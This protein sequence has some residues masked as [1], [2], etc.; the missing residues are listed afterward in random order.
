MK[1]KHSFVVGAAALVIALFF[2]ACSNPNNPETNYTVTI[3]TLTNGS[4]TAAPQSGPEGTTIVLTVEPDAGYRQKA[5]SLKYNNGSAD[6]AITGTSFALPAANVTVS[7]EFEL[8]PANYNVIIAALTNGNVTAAPQ[9]GPQGTTIVLTVEPDA[10]YRLKADS[11]KYND[12]SVDVPITGTSFVMPDA[13]VTVSAEFETVP[14]GS[15]TVAIAS[16]TNGSVTAAPQYGPVGTTIVLTV[17][18]D[19]GYRLKADSLKYNNGSADVAITGTSFALP[20]VNVMVSAEFEIIPGANYTVTIASPIQNGS[21]AAAPAGGPVGTNIALTVT[22]NNG[23]RLKP[24][25]LKY[26]NGSADVAI[27]GTSFALPAANVTVTAEFEIIPA[28]YTVTIAPLTNGSVAATPQSG[29]QGTT[30]ALTVAPNNGYRLKAGSLKY[31]NGSADVAITGASFALPAANVTVTAEFEATVPAGQKVDEGIEALVEG[32]FDAAID[33][34][35]AA[36]QQDH[37][38]RAAIIYSSL[39]R[40]ASIAKDQNVRNLMRDRLGL[41]EYP[42]T[43]DSLIAGEWIESYHQVGLPGM[44]LPSWFTETGS[45]TNNLTGDGTLLRGSAWPLLLFANLAD[46]NQN[47]LNT[48]LDGILSSVFGSVFEDAAGRFSALSYDQFIEVDEDVIDA[49]GLSELLEGDDLYIGK[50]EL[51][52]LF[53]AVRLVKATLEWVSAYDWNTDVSFLQ[54][55]WQTLADRIDTLTPGSL[56]LRNNFMKDRGNGNMAKSKA[57]FLKAIEDAA[58]T[59]DHLA[60]VDSELP[61][62]YVDKLKENGWVKDGL[63]KLKN[64]IQTGGVFYVLEQAPSGNNY[65][66]LPANAAIGFNMGKLFTP[67]WLAIDQVIE[68]ESDGRSP[69]FYA[70]S[71]WHSDGQA[72]FTKDHIDSLDESW[73][74]GF[75]FKLNHIAE[76]VVLGLEHYERETIS[77]FP[78]QLGKDLYA[79][80]HK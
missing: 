19:A 57:D 73:H 31:N 59:Y 16:L 14:S 4:V 78:A 35:E 28:T 72:I 70:F 40:L 65:P 68:T 8:I 24:G 37:A 56:P 76:V 34:F 7:A 80:Y 17:E 23:Y 74:V 21:V 61:K 20:A 22:P 54:S 13:N 51:D 46:K 60:G 6:A 66:N 27:T 53:S 79:L 42:G 69:Q 58:G 9:S 36:Y 1:M 47:G 11:L 25:S 71:E 64:A 33:A 38:N 3:A 30:I 44:D 48:L 10:G 75:K 32:S 49:F 45:Y 12:G 50:A 29:P 39:G 5:D 41:K 43:I 2:S 63:T 62:G 15:Y 55:D 26:N 77:L 67:G 52:L 18:P